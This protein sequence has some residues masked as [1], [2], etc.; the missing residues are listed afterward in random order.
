MRALCLLPLALAA[1]GQSSVAMDLGKAVDAAI[2]ND[3]AIAVDAAVPPDLGANDD[4]FTP[5][6][7]SGAKALSFAPAALYGTPGVAVYTLV[8]ADLN[9]DGKT[10]LVVGGV[11]NGNN[12]F[13]LLNTG[14]GTFKPA[15]P[16]AI[17]GVTLSAVVADLNGDG[18]PDIVAADL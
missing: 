2:A 13:V 6:D 18:K 8:A 14:N 17:A 1:C 15:V 3:A 16:Y 9:G 4:L 5:A 7:L 11:A 12:L 10:D